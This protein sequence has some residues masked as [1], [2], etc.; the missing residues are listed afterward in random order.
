ML[1]G[2]NIPVKSS[3]AVIDKPESVNLVRPPTATIKI[4]NKNKVISHSLKYFI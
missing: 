3:Q 4:I 2:G 1:R